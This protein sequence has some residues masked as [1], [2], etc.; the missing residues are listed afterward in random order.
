MVQVCK[1]TKLPIAYSGGSKGYPLDSG[2]LGYNTESLDV[3]HNGQHAWR[4][5]APSRLN[6][7]FVYFE[8]V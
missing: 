6:T 1:Q 3:D 8:Q 4:S 2:L 7:S 5:H